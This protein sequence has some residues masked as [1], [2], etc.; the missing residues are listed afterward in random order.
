[1]GLVEDILGCT[2]QELATSFW[3]AKLTS[4][5]WVCNVNQYFDEGKKRY[6]FMNWENDII[7]TGEHKNITELWLFCPPSPTLPDGETAHLIITRPCT[8]FQVKR[9]RGKEQTHIIGR[10]D[11][12]AGH[13]TCFIWD[14]AQGSLTG[15]TT[16]LEHLG[17]TL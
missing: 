16:T 4:G 6:R 14:A 3:A 9:G 11:D 5:E 10:L 7:A 8:A 17:V 12:D 2:L 15:E 13:C 1:M